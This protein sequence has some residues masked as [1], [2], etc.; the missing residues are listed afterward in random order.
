MRVEDPRAYAKALDCMELDVQRQLLMQAGREPGGGGSAGGTHEINLHIVF[1]ALKRVLSFSDL[2]RKNKGCK[3]VLEATIDKV[4]KQAFDILAGKGATPCEGIEDILVKLQNL[5]IQRV[6]LPG[7]RLGLD[8]ARDLYEDVIGDLDENMEYPSH[9]ELPAPIDVA[10]LEA[11]ASIAAARQSNEDTEDHSNADTLPFV[12]LKF[13]QSKSWLPAALLE[14][15][16]LEPEREA[17]AQAGFNAKLPSGAKIFVPPDAFLPVVRHLGMHNLTLKSSHV[18]VSADLEEKVLSV[19]Q[20]ARE[21][22]TRR[23]R[24]SCK[25]AERI[26]MDAAPEYK[27]KR[28][29]I[30]VH[31]PSSLLSS[32]SI[33]PFTV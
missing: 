24:G 4:S 23:E 5:K 8:K 26:G 33:K 25:V 13:S 16:E 22:A 12:L 7:N 19:V 18:V 9:S 10:E 30:H 29:F 21:A 28:T 3:P 27:T 31:V 17:L 32:L 11:Q 14:G 6:G 15:P 2:V 20:V 1:N